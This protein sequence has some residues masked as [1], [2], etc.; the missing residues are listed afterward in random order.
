MTSVF[1]LAGPASRSRSPPYFC[2]LPASGAAPP[3]HHPQALCPAAEHFRSDAGRCRRLCRLSLLWHEI[4]HS[5]IVHVQQEPSEQTLPAVLSAAAV[6]LWNIRIIHKS[7]A[8]INSRR[9]SWCRGA[10]SSCSP[11]AFTTTPPPLSTAC[12]RSRPGASSP[13]MTARAA[14]TSRPRATAFSSAPPSGSIPNTIPSPPC[15]WT[16]ATTISSPI[17]TSSAGTP[18]AIP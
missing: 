16:A 10:W 2:F 13:S 1:S 11:P 4:H 14:R 15:R 9:C 5:V 3:K 18:C 7:A 12:L 17:T 6:R 8:K